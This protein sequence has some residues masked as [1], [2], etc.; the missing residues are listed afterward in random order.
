MQL[1]DYQQHA[2]QLA[3]AGGRLVVL[4]ADSEPVLRQVMAKEGF[5]HSFVHTNPETWAGWGLQNERRAEIPYP[6]TFIV[7]PDGALVYREVHIRH[8]IRAH[9]PDVIERIEAWRA[10]P[11]QIAD[12][13]LEPVP[14]QAAHAADEPDWDHPLSIS[15]SLQPSLLLVEL[16]I[17]PGFHV[18]GA[19]ETLSRPLALHIDQ[20]PERV[21]PIPPGH[22]KQLGEALGSAWVL[23]GSV[24]LEVPLPTDAPSELSGALDYQVCTDTTCTAP[25]SARWEARLVDDR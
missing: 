12:G 5:T 14:E 8:S 4:T 11:D 23:E 24:V 9:V 20:L 13:G 7:G 2:Q 19:N 17:G 1:R 18:Y 10:A 3:D 16:E 15:A 25:T 22:E 21:P 6:A